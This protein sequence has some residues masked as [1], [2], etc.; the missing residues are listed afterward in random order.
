MTATTPLIS[1]P[2]KNKAE[3]KPAI[4]DKILEIITKNVDG[5]SKS[6]LWNMM[7]NGK[8]EIN[9][10]IEKLLES[11]EIYKS[12]TGRGVKYHSELWRDEKDKKEDNQKT[13]TKVEY[14]DLWRN[15]SEELRSKGIEYLDLMKVVREVTGHDNMITAFKSGTL[16]K[17]H[18]DEIHEKGTKLCGLY[19]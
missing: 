19:S 11:K 15:V 10:A 12:G 5:T 7:I 13:L 18:V 14:N 1:A 17:E 2:N 6:E 8:E 16:T 4:E 3:E 9:L